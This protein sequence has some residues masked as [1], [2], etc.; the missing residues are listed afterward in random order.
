MILPGVELRRVQLLTAPLTF[1][2][3]Q[4]HSCFY[5]CWGDSNPLRFLPFSGMAL[6]SERYRK[7]PS[8]NNKKSSG[9]RRSQQLVPTPTPTTKTISDPEAKTRASARPTTATTR[10]AALHTSLS[11][12]CFCSRAETLSLLDGGGHGRIDQ[13]Y[14]TDDDAGTQQQ[15]RD[16]L[17]VADGQ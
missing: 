10:L 5:K 3:K 13:G 8:H 7:S 6:P 16:V 9:G 11:G 4:T 14:Y 15:H 1:T 17:C 12:W 2:M